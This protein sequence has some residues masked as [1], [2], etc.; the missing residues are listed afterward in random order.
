MNKEEFEKILLDQN[1]MEL[2]S[3]YMHM[4]NNADL[5]VSDYLIEFSLDE[6]KKY[7][8][9][10][11]YDNDD[12]LLIVSYIYSDEDYIDLINMIKTRYSYISSILHE[13]NN[14]TEQEQFPIKGKP[15][16]MM[17]KDEVIKKLKDNE[18][19]QRQLDR[20][21]RQKESL[22]IMIK[23]IDNCDDNKA[24]QD[25]KDLKIKSLLK[26]V[27]DIIDYCISDKYADK[28]LDEN[29]ILDFVDGI[30]DSSHKLILSK[31]IYSVFTLDEEAKLD[32]P[33]T[34]FTEELDSKLIRKLV[35]YNI[36]TLGELRR[37]V[38][39]NESCIKL[40]NQKHLIQIQTLI[41]M[42]FKSNTGLVGKKKF[43]ELKNRNKGGKENE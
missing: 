41:M 20:F 7:H 11:V 29:S 17:S 6:S 39:S 23:D 4:L 38:L 15:I 24:S 1:R 36:N 10:K 21:K 22:E 13:T 2:R 9:I 25:L 35:K 12:M 14:S 3:T 16:N 18:K 8:R 43:N 5:I 33:I 34:K 27:C 32:I 26:D 28:V 30:I 31:G 42:N 37:K 19:H 40:L